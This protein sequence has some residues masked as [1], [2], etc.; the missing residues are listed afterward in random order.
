MKNCYLPIH[1]SLYAITLA[2]FSCTLD[3]E[4]D[5]PTGANNEKDPVFD[6]AVVISDTNNYFQVTA[7]L[8]DPGNLN[9][10]QHGWEWS[11]TPGL[12]LP[13]DKLK[14]GSLDMESFDTVITGL[15][16]G[17]V[18]YLRPF[19][20]TGSDTTYYG[21]ELC[22]F[23]GV[24]F[25]I[26]PGTK[27]YKGLEV[28]FINHTVDNGYSY[29]WEFGDG[30]ASILYSPPAHIYD[31]IGNLTVQLTV[32]ANDTCIVTR[33][34]V[35]EIT[36]PF[37]DY[38]TLI[39]GSTFMMGCTADQ[40]PDCSQDDKDE[41]LPALLVTLASFYIGKTEITQGQWLAVMGDEPSDFGTCGLDCPVENVS[42]DRIVNE[43]IPA[44]NQKTGKTHR[45]PTEAEW[46][47][48]ARS[49]LDASSM[50][51]YAGSDDLNK[52]GW[53]SDNSGDTTN[54][55]RQLD[56]NAF[57]LY[58]MSGNVFEWVEDDYH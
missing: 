35:L 37:E 14:L 51:R 42:W 38:W 5:I 13:D 4:P 28:Q 27:I 39:P 40:E 31:T 48:A 45:L 24:D 19:V 34:I 43:F 54:P 55:V 18:Y 11:E 33:E 36:D 44:L 25:D 32:T 21:P 17:K 2:F 20:S 57:G 1:L 58:D 12:Y 26:N 47:Y 49:G 22:S 29:M 10:L 3:K 53:Y 16:V 7:W 50:T 6:T 9:I 41:A 56:P 52:V 30:D 23:L 46:E 15:D 8:S